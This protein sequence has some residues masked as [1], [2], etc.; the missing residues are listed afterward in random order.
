MVIVLNQKNLSPNELIEQKLS[1]PYSEVGDW[2]AF[3]SSLLE[4]VDDQELSLHRIAL[5]NFIEP[6]P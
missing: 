6:L 3:I 5:D 2:P 4:C 1:Q